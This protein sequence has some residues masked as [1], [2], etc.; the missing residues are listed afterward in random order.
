MPSKFIYNIPF[1]MSFP[2]SIQVYTR[3]AWIA[4]ARTVAQLLKGAPPQSC[5]LIASEDRGADGV[6]E[7]LEHASRVHAIHFRLIHKKGDFMLHCAS[8][9]AVSE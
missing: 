3:D 9:T 7:F 5:A 8:N 2:F 4:L 6:N 1:L